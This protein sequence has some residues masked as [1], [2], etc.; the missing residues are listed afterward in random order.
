MPTL[1]YLE[2]SFDCTT[3]IKGNDYI[4]LLDENGILIASFEGI[5]DFSAFTLTNGEYTTPT[6]ENQCY[7]AVIRDD[8]TIAKGGHRCSDISNHTHDDRYYT[9]SE[10]DTKLAGKANSSHTHDDRYYTESE[11]DTKLAGKADSS[12]NHAAGNITS[13]TLGVARGG[14]GVTANPSMLTNLGSTTA[15][16]VFAA[17]PRPGVTGT[18]PVANG[19]TGST[20]AAAARTALGAASTT[21]Y[22]ATVSTTWTGS[23]S[24]FY[25][26]ITVSGILAT[27]TPVVGVNYG[28]DSAANV[29]YSDAMSNVFRVATSANTIQVWVK[30]KP[31]ISFPIQIKVVR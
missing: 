27:D 29:Q 7:L 20:T 21:R 15:A 25:Q 9:E 12:H 6:A 26:N 13:G 14:T 24:P 31:T 16:S 10:V 2:N 4:R 19:G 17:S 28:S 23:S 1:T 30:D 11:I 18:L 3:A 22:T 8:G 5:A